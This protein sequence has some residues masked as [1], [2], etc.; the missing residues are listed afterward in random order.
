MSTNKIDEVNVNEDVEYIKTEE[1]QLG[2][3][4]YRENEEVKIE[5]VQAIK[6][7]YTENEEVKIEEV[8][9]IKEENTEETLPAFIGIFLK[10]RQTMRKAVREPKMLMDIVISMIMQVMAFSLYVPVF[11]K[12]T[13]TMLEQQFQNMSP[14]EVE[15]FESM[16]INSSII[17]QVIGLTVG[18]V[19]AWIISAIVIRLIVKILGGETTLKQ[20][21]S[22]VAK[23]LYID[24]FFALISAII[25]MIT[26]DI[27]GA[28]IL[29][30]GGLVANTTEQVMSSNMLLLAVASR[31]S[32]PIIWK[33]VVITIGVEEISGIGRKKSIIAAVILFTLVLIIGFG[34]AFITQ[35]FTVIN[36]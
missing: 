17:G 14:G 26:N 10:P 28:N 19:A 5:E 32:I 27:M 25:I 21:C 2:K 35:I 22:V 29:S 30:L 3:E 9:V 34:S 7:E 20:F 23:T 16:V 36:A 13:T 24:A 8:Q 12:Y 18:A 1:V 31:F 15:M 33:Y 6:E 4:V 11:I